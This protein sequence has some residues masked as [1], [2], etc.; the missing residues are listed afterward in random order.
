LDYVYISPT[1]RPGIINI[2]TADARILSALPGV[3]AGLARNIENGISASGDK[4]RPYRNV[5]DLLKVKGMTTDVFCDNAEYLTVRSD[6]YR[7]DILAEIF[8]TP[9]RSKK[10]SQENIAARQNSTYVIEREQMNNEIWKVST[11]EN[12]DINF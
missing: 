5:F 8:K 6:T 3:S 9:P 12:I 4:I 10:V 1:E 11:H 2:N 7:V